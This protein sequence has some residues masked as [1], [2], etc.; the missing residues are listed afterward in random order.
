MRFLECSTPVKAQGESTV[1]PRGTAIFFTNVSQLPREA[2]P[3]P[4]DAGMSLKCRVD[5]YVLQYRGTSRVRKRIPLGP[6]RRPMAR[7][8]GRSWVG[9]RFLMGEVA[10]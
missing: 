2:G 8:L 6:Y 7:V 3:I 5:T 4:P 9:L 1:A 10:M